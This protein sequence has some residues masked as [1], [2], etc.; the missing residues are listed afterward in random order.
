MRGLER[1]WDAFLGVEDDSDL[2]EPAADLETAAVLKG[3]AI[4]HSIA[5]DQH[6]EREEA[7]RVS[8]QP[9]ASTGSTD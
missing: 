7:P 1:P 5:R 9:R 2:F 6:E 4:R 8:R 3:L